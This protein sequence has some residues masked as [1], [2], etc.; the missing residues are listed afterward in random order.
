LIRHLG[1]A[2]VQSYAAEGLGSI[3]QQPEIA[4]PALIK[5][6]GPSASGS[7]NSY[8][9]VLGLA[10]FGKEASSSVPVLL[11]ILREDHDENPSLRRM[12]TNAIQLIDPEAAAKAG[13]NQ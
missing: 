11:K 2:R 12:I 7:D 3:H 1:D 13:L 5:N 10:G 8:F 9:A 6:I 4:V